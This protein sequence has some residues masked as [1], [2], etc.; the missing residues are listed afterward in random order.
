[1]AKA[2]ENRRVGGRS[3]NARA[4]GAGGTGMRR[5]IA[6]VVLTAVG[7]TLF[8]SLVTFSSLDGQL[9]DRGLPPASNLA[10]RVGHYAAWGLYRAFG[11]AAMVLP[12]GLLAFSWKLFRRE[13][14][15]I[16]VVSAG[17]WS[18]LLVSVAT[19][20]HLALASRNLASGI[21]S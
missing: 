15:R 11:F 16:T 10:G 4:G 9:I 13:T 2:K 21:A 18:V 14:V 12:P 8:L 5:D 7:L 6:A 19:L 1:M 17:A 3:G 20:G